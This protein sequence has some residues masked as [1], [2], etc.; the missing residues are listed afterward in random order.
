MR[1]TPGKFVEVG[2]L[3]CNTFYYCNFFQ[4]FTDFELIKR[5][6]FKADLTGLSS[7]RLIATLIANSPYLLFE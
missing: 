1:M 5:F 7:D 4:I 3:I 2:N 6:W